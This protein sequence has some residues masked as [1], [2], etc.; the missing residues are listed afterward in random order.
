MSMKDGVREYRVDY[1]KWGNIYSE[2]YYRKSDAINLCFRLKDDPDV[3]RRHEIAIIHTQSNRQ[4]A[5]DF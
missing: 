4:L 1:V 3:E 5:W 2:W